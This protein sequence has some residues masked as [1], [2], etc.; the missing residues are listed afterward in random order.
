MY[1][2][3]I[4]SGSSGNCIFIGSNKTKILIDVGVSRKTIEDSLVKIKSTP[5][6]IKGVLITHEHMDH[7]KGVGVLCKKYNI[8]V[9]INNL[10]YEAMRDKLEGIEINIIEN[11]E[12]S[13]G[14]LDIKTFSLPHDAVDPIGY[15]II[16][17]KKK[18]SVATDL[19]HVSQEVFDNLKDSN[20]VLIES[21]YNKEM[22]KISHYPY[23]LKQRILSEVGHLSNEECGNVIVELIKNFPKKIILGHLSTTNNFP[24]LAYKTVEEILKKNSLRIGKDLELTVAHRSLPSNYMRI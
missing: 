3:S 4:S 15:S 16:N 18:I 1:F 22:V 13:I 20:I 23:F 5:E 11:S 19:G 8:P 9:F 2:C 24:E 7:N 14:D 10:T 6:D 21:N 12:F 17:N